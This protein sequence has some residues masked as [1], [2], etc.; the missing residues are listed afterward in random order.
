[1]D[2]ADKDKTTFTSHCDIF[3]FLRMHFSLKNV[4][5]TLSRA[6][7]VIFSKVMWQYALVYTDDVIIYS[8]DVEEHFAHVRY[9]LQLL[10]YAGLTLKLEKCFF[11]NPQ[12]IN[13]G[14]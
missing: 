9:V 6:L 13:W 5:A 4:P 10:M 14:A 7:D 12:W 3:R 2:D 11:S 1:M 8:R